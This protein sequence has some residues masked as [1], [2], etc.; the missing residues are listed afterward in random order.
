MRALLATA[1]IL[2]GMLFLGGCTTEE[3][4][5]EPAVT[6]TR[7]ATAAA[8]KTPTSTPAGAV[9]SATP[10]HLV[11]RPN[12]P[13]PTPP[14]PR[15]PDCWPADSWPQPTVAPADVVTTAP[16]PTVVVTVV[17]FRPHAD[18]GTPAP[19]AHADRAYRL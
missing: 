14:R 4:G 2:A 8:T 18:A 3:E 12:L 9:A 6:G 15:L 13:T 5:E 19:C 17:P 10:R 7:A 1:L 16:P 11:Q